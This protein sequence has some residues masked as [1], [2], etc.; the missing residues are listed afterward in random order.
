[1]TDSV[2]EQRYSSRAARPTIV[3]DA[4]AGRILGQL[5]EHGKLVL[6]DEPPVSEPESWPQSCWT[7]IG[8]IPR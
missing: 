4:A 7:Y 2:L 5:D 3:V 6:L 1:M 8:E